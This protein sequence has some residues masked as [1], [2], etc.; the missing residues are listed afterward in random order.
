MQG[1]LW[2]LLEQNYRQ[3]LWRDLKFDKQFSHTYPTNVTPRL[4]RL[5]HVFWRGVWTVSEPNGH[6]NPLRFNSITFHLS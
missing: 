1:F 2:S 6:I 5:G 3:S 4:Y